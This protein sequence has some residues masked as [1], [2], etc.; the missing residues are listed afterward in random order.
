MPDWTA[1]FREWLG[2]VHT[3]DAEKEHVDR[4]VAEQ[5]RRIARIDAGLP[6]ARVRQMYPH[7]H[8]RATDRR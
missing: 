8:R 1:R 5:K 7:P 4:V 3:P 2:L 6:R